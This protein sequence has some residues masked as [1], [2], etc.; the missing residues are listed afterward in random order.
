[1]PGLQAR[2]AV[3]GNQVYELG[4]ANS[5]N[6]QQAHVSAIKNSGRFSHG[7]MFGGYGRIPQ[8]HE[9]SGE[10]DDVGF[11]GQFAVPVV[12]DGSPGF[13]FEPMES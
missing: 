2:G 3:G 10:W 8:R 6:L 13:F 9:I 11:V 5:R 4:G 7:I 12:Q 1:M